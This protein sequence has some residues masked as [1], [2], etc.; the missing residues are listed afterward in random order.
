MDEYY[1]FRGG[2][3]RV[4]YKKLRIH[5]FGS[6]KPVDG[7]IT[8]CDSTGKTLEVSSIQK[9]GIHSTVAELEDRRA[10]REKVAGGV[11]QYQHK[12]FTIGINTMVTVYSAAI[13]PASTFANRDRFRGSRIAGTSL[14]LAWYHHW[15]GFSGEAAVANLKQALNHVMVF[16]INDNTTLWVSSRFYAPG[17][18]TPYGA[19]IGRGTSPTGEKGFNVVAAYTPKYGTVFRVK[20]DVY[21]IISTAKSPVGGRHGRTLYA[22]VM[23]G[24][25]ETTA[26][27]RISGETQSETAPMTPS[28]ERLVASPGFSTLNV[29][30]ELTWMVKDALKIQCRFDLRGKS[31]LEN[32]RGWQMVTGLDYRLRSQGWRFVFRHVLYH[33]DHYDLRIYSREAEAPGAYSMT[34]LYGRGQRTSLMVHY[35]NNRKV[36]V[37]LKAGYTSVLKPDG[38]QTLTRSWD[39]SAQLN[40]SI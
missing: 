26:L 30:G 22:E 4:Q 7:N 15:F 37:W 40:L 27:F 13:E 23:Q 21:H 2:A 25:G 5:M 31:N 12:Q 34:M 3:V 18:F 1:Y 35:K 20:S 39:F 16:K 29:R 36:Q 10:F 38:A 28:S 9:T 14:N 24:G 8:I 6:Y 19:S 11:I 33:I 32:T 17:Y